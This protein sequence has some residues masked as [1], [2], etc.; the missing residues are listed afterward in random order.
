M[1]KKGVIGT[2]AVV[3]IVIIIAA[4][5]IIFT[6]NDND[7]ESSSDVDVTSENTAESEEADT[8]SDTKDAA[9]VTDEQT[10]E[11]ESESEDTSEN[12]SDDGTI[13]IEQA[14]QMLYDEF[15]TE[16]VDTGYHY[17]FTYESTDTVDGAEY[18]NFRMTWLVEDHS[19]YL[20][21]MFVSTDGSKIYSGASDGDGGWELYYD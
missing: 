2:A 14:E 6:G 4:A 15:G 5:V 8:E 20:T 18:Y 21:N 10:S 3:V 17:T 13:T 1:N 16:D 19:S 7:S 9:D 12:N 11:N